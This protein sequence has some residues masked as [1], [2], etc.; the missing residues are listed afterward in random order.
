[1][2][3][4]DRAGAGAGED[5]VGAVHHG[6]HVLVRAHA[7]PHDVARGGQIARARGDPHGG[8]AEGGEGLGAASPDRERI[9]G[10]GDPA[11]HRR[12]EVPQPDEPDVDGG[13]QAL[14]LAS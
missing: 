7:Q 13:T 9:A 12:T 3:G 6:A 2:D 10:G 14:S 8:L 11:R 1:V 4:D 5:A